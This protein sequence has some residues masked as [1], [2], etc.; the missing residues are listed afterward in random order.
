[1]RI[2][3]QT[4]GG[5]VRGDVEVEGVVT[6]SRRNLNSLNLLKWLLHFGTMLAFRMAGL[7][8]WKGESAESTRAMKVQ[9]LGPLTVRRRFGSWRCRLCLSCEVAFAER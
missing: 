4:E 9:S 7:K 2:R 6:I 8:S 1:M 3:K 5:R